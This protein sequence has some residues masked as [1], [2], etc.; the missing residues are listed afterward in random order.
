MEYQANLS[1]LRH[2]NQVLECWDEVVNGVVTSSASIVTTWIT[3]ILRIHRHRLHRLVVGLDIEW[4]PNQTPY[5][6]NPVTTLQL[7]V[8]RICPV[9]QILHANSI[10]I[11]LIEFLGH[12]DFTFVG[13]GIGS[14]VEKLWEDYGVWV[15]RR[16]ELG[17][18]AEVRDVVGLRGMAREVLGVDVDKP[19]RITMSRWDNQDFEPLAVTRKIWRRWIPNQSLTPTNNPLLPRIVCFMVLDPG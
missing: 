15:G 10:P 19:W 5:H 11:S 8:G 2:R 9:Y 14:D 6:R 4:R 1:A 7:C 13:V 3:S 18:L 16:V 12:S 17:V